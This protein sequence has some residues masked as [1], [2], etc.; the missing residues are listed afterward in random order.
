MRTDIVEVPFEQMSPVQRA[1]IAYDPT[2]RSTSRCRRPPSTTSAAPCRS[3]VGDGRRVLRHGRHRRRRAQ[4]RHRSRRHPAAWGR[5]TRSSRCTS[6]ATST[7]TTASCWT[8]CSRPRRWRRSSP[9]SAALADELID[10]F[11]GDGHVELHDA[12]CVPLPSTIFLRIF[13]LPVEDAPFLI[14]MKDRILKNEATTRDE[15]EVIGRA[16]GR[17]LDAHLRAPAR[18]ATR[19]AARAT[20]TCST[21]SCTSSSTAT[22][23]TTTRS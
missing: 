19:R 16:A 8:R 14:A 15:A 9:T 5:T 13:G 1:L 17:E 22:V 2:A 4:P 10:G 18:R 3:S 20:T 7:V 12:F 21:S 11:I 6:T 23:S